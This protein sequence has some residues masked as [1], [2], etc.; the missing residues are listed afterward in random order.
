MAPKNWESI[1][2]RTWGFLAGMN[3]GLPG[4]LIGEDKS[5]WTRARR[6]THLVDGPDFFCWMSWLLTIGTLRECNMDEITVG[7][8]FN[9]QS[10]TDE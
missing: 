3:L 7:S 2:K 10:W 9:E 4:V 1:L 6:L 8:E 5:K